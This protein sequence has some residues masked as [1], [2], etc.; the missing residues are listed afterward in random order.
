MNFNKWFEEKVFDK[1]DPA[2]KCV[3]D[4][5]LKFFEK[6]KFFCKKAYSLNRAYCYIS[7]RNCD[8]IQINSKEELDNFIRDCS[9]ELE[10]ET[11]LLRCR[12]ENIFHGQVT[13]LDEDYNLVPPPKEDDEYL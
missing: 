8:I 13:Y 9:L 4:N 6:I 5:L 10:H 3:S 11:N 2:N 1:N 12:Y 7:L